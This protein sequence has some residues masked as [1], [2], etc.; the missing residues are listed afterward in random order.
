MPEPRAGILDHRGGLVA[1]DGA[2]QRPGTP[3][4]LGGHVLGGLAG[5]E[6]EGGERRGDQQHAE[7]EAAEPVAREGRGDDGGVSVRLRRRLYRGTSDLPRRRQAAT[8]IKP[9][10]AISATDDG[11]GTENS[12]MARRGEKSS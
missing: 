5:A 4:E 8:S 9:A 12:T 10:P 1:F 2:L 6:G 7:V 3:V 11:S